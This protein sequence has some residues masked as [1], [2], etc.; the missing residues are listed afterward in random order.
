MPSVLFVDVVE[1][2]P[3]GGRIGSFSSTCHFNVGV[4]LVGDYKALRRSSTNATGR[5]DAAMTRRR[6]GEHAMRT[7]RRCAEQR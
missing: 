4:T 3:S 5:V 2:K 1:D 7:S 6:N